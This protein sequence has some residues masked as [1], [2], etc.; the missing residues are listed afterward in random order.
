MAV[1]PREIP[2]LTIASIRKE[3]LHNQLSPFV[4][5]SAISLLVYLKEIGAAVA[6]N[7]FTVLH[8]KNGKEEENG[9]FDVEVCCPAAKA[10]QDRGDI[11]FR[12][13]DGGKAAATIM[14]GGYDN[15]EASRA[16]VRDWCNT[17][18]HSFKQIRE[19]FLKGPQHTKNSAEYETDVQFL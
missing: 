3:V 18:G 10:G 5:A 19:V 16:K 17:N 14:K 6:G 12:Q 8:L 4:S 2:N 13:I 9:L 15:I 1:E 7:G 11:K